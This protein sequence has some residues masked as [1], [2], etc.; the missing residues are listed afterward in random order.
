VPNL[1][2]PPLVIAFPVIVLF[3][4]ANSCRGVVR[5]PERAIY[6]LTLAQLDIKPR[7]AVFVDDVEINYQAAIEI[8]MFAAHLRSNE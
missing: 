1:K 8:G 6:E 2:E 7:E 4:T 3:V 5:K